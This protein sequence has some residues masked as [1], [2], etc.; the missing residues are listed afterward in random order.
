[1]TNSE[2]MDVVNEKDEVIGNSTRKEIY[3]Q[4][5]AH[6]IVHVLVFNA[7]GKMALQLRSKAMK[8][9]PG[10]W[11]PSAGGHV[12]CGETYDAATAR[13]L[14]EELGIRAHIELLRKDFYNAL[15]L[16]KFIATYTAIHDGKF[17]INE[18][19]EKVQFF[20]LSHIKKMI[21]DGE[22]IHPELLFLLKS[23]FR[24]G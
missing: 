8:F 15:G 22:K 16:G 23:Q 7:E 1:M 10:H 21:A 19:V 9:A 24:I 12:Q 11:A 18:E 6:R 4:L 17:T 13:E 2:L 5:L 14:E 20:D 3:E